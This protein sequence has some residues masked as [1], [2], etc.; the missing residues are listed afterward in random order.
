MSSPQESNDVHDSPK[1]NIEI[2]SDDDSEN[3]SND[4]DENNRT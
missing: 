1:Y 4:D 3:D 2:D